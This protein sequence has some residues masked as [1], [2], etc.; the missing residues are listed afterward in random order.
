MVTYETLL[1]EADAELI[2]VSERNLKNKTKGLY[3]NYVI[4]INKKLTSVEKGCV[5]AEE[6]GHH[7]TTSGDIL[8]QGYIVNRKQEKIARKW[9]YKKL[10]PLSKIVQAS[11]LG[12]R[13]RF[14]L[15][16]HLNV[17]EDFLL[18]AIDRYHEE[19]GICKRFENHII[20]FN[21]LSV[22]EIIE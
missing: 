2:E 14:E 6:L 17:T 4:W 13:S 21:P 18:N 11:K 8:D 1:D 12:I 10:I 16:E 3:C 9:A 22:L 5:L 19:Y 7:Y 20:Y 15:A